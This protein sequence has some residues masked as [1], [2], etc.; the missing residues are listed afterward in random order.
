M[1]ETHVPEADY[2]SV[3][4]ELAP[5]EV[6]ALVALLVDHQRLERD[7]RQ[8]PRLGAGVLP[9]LT[10]SARADSVGVLT[11]RGRRTEAWS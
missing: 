7:R 1:V 11:D 2:E 10:R 6:G 3:A 9:A 4:A 5:A 8:H